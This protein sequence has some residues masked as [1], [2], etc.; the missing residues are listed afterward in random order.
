MGVKFL[1]KVHIQVVNRFFSFCT[2]V[3]VENLSHHTSFTLFYS[4]ILASVA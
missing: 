2:N 1:T 3:F 4:S